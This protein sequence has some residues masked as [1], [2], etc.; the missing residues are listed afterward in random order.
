MQNWYKIFFKI[1]FLERHSTNELQRNSSTKEEEE[2]ESSEVKPIA[3]ARHA[4]SLSLQFDCS[5]LGGSN[6]KPF[7]PV[8]RLVETNRPAREIV[9]M[10]ATYLNVSVRCN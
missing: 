8:R 2:E 5:C 1:Q 4:R 6:E 10:V 9:T 7:L 3:S